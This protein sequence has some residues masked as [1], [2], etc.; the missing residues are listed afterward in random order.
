MVTANKYNG[1]YSV[2]VVNSPNKMA[3]TH[4]NV[5]LVHHTRLCAYSLQNVLLLAQMIQV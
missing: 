1:K 2:H 3:L 5:L 4:V